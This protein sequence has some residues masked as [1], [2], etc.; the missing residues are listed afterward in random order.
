M[1]RDDDLSNLFM[2]LRSCLIRQ[3]GLHIEWRH[4]LHLKFDV[5][6][7]EGAANVLKIFCGD[8]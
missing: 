6:D 3:V 1:L 5:A 2:N 7:V 4:Q 8:M